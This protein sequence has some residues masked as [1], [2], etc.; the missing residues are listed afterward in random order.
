MIR[1][2]SAVLEPDFEFTPR[3]RDLALQRRISINIKQ[4]YKHKFAK[5]HGHGKRHTCVSSFAHRR[6]KTTSS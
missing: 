3:A 5:S 1:P 6:L 4:E 2:T